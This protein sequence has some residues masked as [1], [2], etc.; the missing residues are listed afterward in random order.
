MR[1]VTAFIGPELAAHPLM[2]ELDRDVITE[3][4]VG[5]AFWCVDLT[6]EPDADGRR[7]A[8]ELAPLAARVIVRGPEAVGTVVVIG[9][10]AASVRDWLRPLF[11]SVPICAIGT[12][13]DW[14]GAA[15]LLGAIDTAVAKLTGVEVEQW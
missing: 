12:G 6:D 4:L 2:T 15:T 7:P 3:D 14:P 9:T 13:F 8:F 11:P 10:R 1:R 5:Q